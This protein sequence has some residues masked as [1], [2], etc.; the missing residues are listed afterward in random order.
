MTGRGD[1]PGGRRRKRAGGRALAAALGTVEDHREF[2]LE[3][4]QWTAFMSMLDA[5]PEDNERLR[6]LLEKKAPWE[7]RSRTE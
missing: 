5:P 7:L 2:E 1:R 3:D 6:K 4:A